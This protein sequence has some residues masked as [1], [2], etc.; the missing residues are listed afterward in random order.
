M[1]YDAAGDGADIGYL[2]SNG[3]DVY[4][5]KDDP[6]RYQSNPKTLLDPALFDDLKR[7]YE[8]NHPDHGVRKETV[9]P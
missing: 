4:G 8:S 1:V 9:D 5:T 7:N 6:K 2:F 3:R